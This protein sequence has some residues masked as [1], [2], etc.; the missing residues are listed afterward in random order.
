MSNELKL[1]EDTTMEVASPMELIMSTASSEA[2]DVAEEEEEEDGNESPLDSEGT[3]EEASERSP[4]K[5]P[6]YRK[7]KEPEAPYKLELVCDNSKAKVGIIQYLAIISWI[8]WFAFYFYFPFIILFL[9]YFSPLC[10]GL[11]FLV[12]IASVIYPCDRKIQ[13]Q[14]GW[15]IGVWI[16]SNAQKYFQISLYCEDYEAIKKGGPA[17]L[18]AEPHDIMPVAVFIFSDHLGFLGPLHKIRGCF[19]SPLYKIPII[20]HIYTW[21]DATDCNKSTIKRLIEEKCTPV[22]CPGGA[23]EVT[24]LKDPNS[25]ELVIYLK[26]RLGMVKIAAEYGVPLIPCFIFGLRQT[27]HYHLPQWPW[28]HSIGRKVG[29]IPLLFF[30]VGGIPFGPPKPCPLTVVLAKPVQ[31]PKLGPNAK[32]EDVQPYH[33]EYLEAMKRI[34]EKNKERFGMGDI[35]LKIL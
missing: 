3:Y 27:W 18:T 10:L 16:V 32:I 34:F 28:L 8:G 26:N 22:I 4:F 11:L 35:T 20:K 31:V 33:D 29:F 19:T 5:T 13:P 25:K 9:Y 1:T 12:M 6:R 24:F 2:E 7:K 23:H 15:D 14:W 21:C 17:I 30:G